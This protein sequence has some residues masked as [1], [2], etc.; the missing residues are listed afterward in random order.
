MENRQ[1]GASH[2]VPI[3]WKIIPVL[4]LSWVPWAG[5]DV[6]FDA[7]CRSSLASAQTAC[8]TGDLEAGSDNPQA[9]RE[10]VNRLQRI[11]QTVSGM[12]SCN[13]QAVRHL[14]MAAQSRALAQLSF[15]KAKACSRSILLCQGVCGRAEM[16]LS[17]IQGIYED[18]RFTDRAREAQKRKT[19]AA[20]NSSRCGGFQAQVQQARSQEM[21]EQTNERDNMS[22][23]QN[24]AINA[25]ADVGEPA[26]GAADA[27]A[28]CNV[29]LSLVGDVLRGD[30]A[31][32]ESTQTGVLSLD[33]GTQT[34]R[35]G[36]SFDELPGGAKRPANRAAN[37]AG[38]AAG[39]RGGSGSEATI[40]KGGFA[41]QSTGTEILGRA[42][43]PSQ[44]PAA[45][46]TRRP[47]AIVQGRGPASTNGLGSVQGFR[48]RPE[49]ADGV[50][51]ATGLSLFE[52]VSRRYRL[53]IGNLISD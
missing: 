10:L 5:A 30:V 15:M 23:Y 50:T 40:S 17:T 12:K 32:Q 44:L 19:A 13:N 24:L 34:P 31:K 18:Y 47:Y 39:S 3:S 21:S 36:P 37:V 48:H 51:S 53:E 52:K 22:S 8:T 20:D 11:Q 1:D 35:G 2:V 45:E 41:F 26:P 25:K 42:S 4:I 43:S 14:Y 9:G 33:S 28:S 38:S 27:N 6:G 46:S 29:D 7:T 16:D 49:L